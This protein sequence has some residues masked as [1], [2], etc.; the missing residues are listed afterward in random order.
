[1]VVTATDEEIADALKRIA[2]NNKSYEAREEGA[3][4]ETGDAVVIDFLGKIDGEAF[5]GG[6]A[7]GQTI[8]LGDGR[9]IAG[10]E[11][12]LIGAK[13]GDDVEVNVTFPEE[14]QV[15]TLK[16]KP[17]VFDVKVTEVKAPKSP[18][19]TTNLPRRLASTGSTSCRKP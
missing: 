1:M 19:S 17:A 16:G 5:D 12:Q 7:E 15:E 8:V 6:S 4:A 14:Y 11:D 3:A 2:E 18:R 13:A 10:F 9:F